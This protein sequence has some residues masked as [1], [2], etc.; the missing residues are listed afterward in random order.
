[1]GLTLLYCSKLQ[2]SGRLIVAHNSRHGR[3]R[4]EDAGKS[5]Y[6]RINRAKAITC[7]TI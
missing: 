1:M 7:S 6:I 3:M 4:A 2:E 5:S